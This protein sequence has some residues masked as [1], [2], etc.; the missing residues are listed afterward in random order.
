MEE[1]DYAFERVLRH[2]RAT[3]MLKGWQ[4]GVDKEEADDIEVPRDFEK[5]D[6]GHNSE[7]AQRERERL[8]SLCE[9]DAVAAEPRNTPSASGSVAR[10]AGPNVDSLGRKR[11]PQKP[12]PNEPVERTLRAAWLGWAQEQW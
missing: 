7:Q 4:Q 3:V 1:D 2:D 12:L 8:R 10:S 5:R 11:P 6:D 9:F